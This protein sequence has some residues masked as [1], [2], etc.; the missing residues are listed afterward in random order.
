MPMQNDQ[1]FCI[2]HPNQL[3]TRN[4]GFSAL[5]KVDKKQNIITF[6]PSSGVP[7]IVFY[8]PLCGYV[9][10]Y[11]AHPNEEWKSL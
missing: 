2:N 5:T 1:V 4:T 7:I 10:E 6:N 11:A 8:C 9:E 3:M